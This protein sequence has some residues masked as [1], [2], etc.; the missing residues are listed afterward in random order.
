M[1]MT[2]SVVFNFCPY[3]LFIFCSNYRCSVAV[4][5]PYYYYIYYYYKTSN[6]KRLT[7]TKHDQ[8]F[9]LLKKVISVICITIKAYAVNADK[10]YN[11]N[12]NQRNYFK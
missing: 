12:I 3:Y 6:Q 5:K 4:G 11:L 1:K 10:K 2:D 8:K 7:K 9:E